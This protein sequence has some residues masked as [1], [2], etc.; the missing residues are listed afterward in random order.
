M[1]DSKYKKNIFKLLFF[2]E[3]KTSNYIEVRT[4]A[5]GGDDDR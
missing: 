4:R 5:E 2:Q 1:I 3:K